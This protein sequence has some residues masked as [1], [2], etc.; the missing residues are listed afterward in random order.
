M[1]AE[2]AIKEAASFFKITLR[3]KQ[4][5]VIRYFTDWN[6]VFVNLPTGFGKSFCYMMLPVHH[7]TCYSIAGVT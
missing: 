1:A 2:A 6:D 3:E 4:E 7:Y 5:R